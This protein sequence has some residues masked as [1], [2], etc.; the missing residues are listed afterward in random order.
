MQAIRDS[1]EGLPKLKEV[2]LYRT[3]ANTAGGAVAALLGSG[4]VPS[5]EYL[6]VVLLLFD[7]EGLGAVEE[8]VRTGN[9]PSRLSDPF[10][11]RLCEEAGN[12]NVDGLITAIVESENGLPPVVHSLNLRGGRIGE[13]TLAALAAS[14]GGGVSG[15]K[16]SSLFFLSLRDCAIDDGRLRQWG[17]I[18]SAHVCTE[19]EF[20]DLRDN[21]IS[22]EGVSGFFAVLTPDALPELKMLHLF[23]QEG[24]EGKEEHRGFV[25][26]VR[27]LRDAAHA[28]GKLLKWKDVT[29]FREESSEEESEGDESDESESEGDGSSVDEESSLESSYPADESNS[30]S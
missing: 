23:T 6:D 8:A 15:G 4:K 25:S 27:A 29:A 11:F 16:F 28:E 12:L 9:F 2:C 3:T 13:G 17:E 18:L 1:E 5:V 20:L 22:V 14:S 19:L 21:R 24:L 10:T 7:E 26:S 30:Q